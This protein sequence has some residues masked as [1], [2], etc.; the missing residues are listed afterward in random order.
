M[1][2]V[3]IVGFGTVG[4]AVARLLIGDKHKGLQLTHIANRNVGRKK[5]DWIPSS[6]VWTDEMSPIIGSDVDVV[7]ELIGG[8]DAASEWIRESL[9][10]GKSVVT[11]NKQVIADVGPELIALAAGNDRNILF[12]AAVACLLYTSPSP[13]D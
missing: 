13:R 9:M 2:K 6:V 8:I 10:N 4:Q 1:L 7:V 5:V 11:A 12:E 3:A